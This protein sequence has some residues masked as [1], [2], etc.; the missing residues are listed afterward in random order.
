M[1]RKKVDKLVQALTSWQDGLMHIGECVVQFQRI[2]DCLSACIGRFIG[3]NRLI[4]E[5]VTA[6]MSYRVK[7]SVFGAL[8][9]QKLNAVCLPSDVTELI[10]RLHWAEEQRNTL[11]HSL[12]NASEANPDSVRREKKAIR[13]KVFSM[14]TEHRTPEELEDLNR[15]L[16][17]IITDLIFFTC[18]H[19]PNIRPV[20]P[21]R[22]RK[23]R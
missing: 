15:A 1:Q 5:I 22:R 2:D 9:Q 7:V 21:N 14:T 12:W 11:V 19:F 10:G 17:G 18:E 20:Y 3:S 6:E 16:E 13:K 23:K 4:G 8:F